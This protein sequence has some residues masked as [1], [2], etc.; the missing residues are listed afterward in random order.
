LGNTGGVVRRGI[1]S[2]LSMARVESDLEFLER[3]ASV[4]LV[5]A[6]RGLVRVRRLSEGGVTR[7]FEVER[8]DGA[9]E[10]VVRPGTVRRSFSVSEGVDAVS[11]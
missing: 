5:G 10:A 9:T 4:G 11:S 3:V 6:T 2:V 8:G 1:V 7:G